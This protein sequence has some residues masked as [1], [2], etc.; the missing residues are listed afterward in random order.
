MIPK[1]RVMLPMTERMIT[2]PKA[3]L[4]IAIPYITRTKIQYFYK[5]T[6]IRFC[7]MKLTHRHFKMIIVTFQ[8]YLYPYFIMFRY[9]DMIILPMHFVERVLKLD[10]IFHSVLILFNILLPT[11]PQHHV[12]Y[13]VVV[14]MHTIMQTPY[15]YHHSQK[16]IPQNISNNK[17]NNLILISMI[18]SIMILYKVRHA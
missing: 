7:S 16:D 18:V 9:Y 3:L 4:L 10:C 13:Y 6:Q 5:S 2:Y 17:S 12:Y 1:H 11:H 8:Q 15:F 14:L